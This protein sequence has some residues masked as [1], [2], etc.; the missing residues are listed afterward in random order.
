MSHDHVTTPTYSYQSV[1]LCSPYH[2]TSDR[3]DS[4]DVN[5]Q[6]FLDIGISKK[7]ISNIMSARIKLF[8]LGIKMLC[9]AS[10]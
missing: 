1:V 6:T 10:A 2:M 8:E 9:R 4:V 3:R 5:T 7:Y